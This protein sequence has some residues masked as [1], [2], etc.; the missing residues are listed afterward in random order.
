V[1]LAPTLPAAKAHPPLA[2]L[3]A[4]VDPFPRWFL[5]RE[6]ELSFTD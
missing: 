1:T 3:A 5:H 6:S 4:V 2:A